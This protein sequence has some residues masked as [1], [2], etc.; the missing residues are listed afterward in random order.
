[1]S[2]AATGDRLAE[3]PAEVAIPALLDRHG[4][5]IYGLGVRLCGGE[6]EAR[7]LVQETF[8]AAF[9]KWN[10]FEGRAEPSTWLYTIAVRTCRRM[11][12]KRAGEPARMASLE[13]LLPA[14]DGGVPALP[15]ADD[16]GPLG[17]QLRRE[18]REAVGRALPAVPIAF[19]VPL[20]LK[21]LAEF[22]VPEVAR[23]L[24]IKEATAKTRIHR[25]RLALRQAIAAALPARAAPPPDHA[26]RV[27]LDLLHAK[28]EALDRGVDFPLPGAEL[29]SR[30]ASLFATLDLARDL[31]YDLGRGDLPSAVSAVLLAEMAAEGRRRRGRRAGRRRAAVD[32]E[33]DAA[34]AAAGA[35][36]RQA[37]RGRSRGRGAALRATAGAA[38]TRRR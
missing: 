15:A 33:D 12:R 31:C 19:R 30:C 34:A 35:T 37:G 24:G 25:G 5:Q 2:E 10:A 38:G 32:P 3:A 21:D 36:N 11:H 13:E 23:V 17:D 14:A 27:C 28:Q 8:L 22:S 9:R 26:R 20:V 6:E 7:D 1:V 4:G 18:A 29:C 16:E